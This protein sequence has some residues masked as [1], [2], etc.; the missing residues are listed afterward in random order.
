[1]RSYPIDFTAV[2]L[3]PAR[4]VRVVRLDGVEFLWAEADESI[5]VTGEGTFVP[6]PGAEVSAVKHILNGEMPSM[7]I[8]FAHSVGG[9]LDTEELNN[10][11]W[12]GAMVQVYVVDRSNIT[13]LGDALFTGVIDTVNLDPVGAAGSFDIRG[14][15][16]QSEAFIQTYQ[17]MD[18]TDLFSVLNQLEPTD[19]DHVGTVGV[20]LDHFNFTVAGLVSPPATGWFNGGVLRT[21]SGFAAVIA[22]WDQSALRVTTYQAVC[23]R[24][25]T[26]GEAVTLYAGYNKTAAQARTKFN[27]K[28]NFQ[29]EDHFLGIKSILGV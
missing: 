28:I 13:T 3:F 26:A 27:N 15:A 6:L 25:I 14:I 8:N 24:R 1:M 9:V 10:G 12:D 20:R 4:L 16:A 17:P 5:D 11:F 21:A 2:T 22:N 29:G 18:R 23:L 19:W 7:E